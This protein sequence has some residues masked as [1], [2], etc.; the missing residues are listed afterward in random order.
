MPVSLLACSVMSRVAAMSCR[1]AA[2]TSAGGE[3]GESGCAP[4]STHACSQAE[5]SKFSR[6][7]R[8]AK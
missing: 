6:A 8:A 3:A 5:K 4:R 2:T 7:L 1:A